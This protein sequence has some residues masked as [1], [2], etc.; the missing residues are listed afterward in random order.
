MVSLI[1]KKSINKENIGIWYNDNKEIKKVVCGAANARDGLLTV[2]APPGAII[3]KNKTKLV[4]AKIRDV[5]S[6][7]M[8]CSESELNLSDESDGITE[9]SSS[10]YAKKIGKSYFS[11]QSSNLIDLSTP[12]NIFKSPNDLIF[13]S[14]VVK[15]VISLVEES[16][17][18]SNCLAL[19]IPLELIFPEAVI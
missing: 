7:G 16:D 6:Y 5:T 4:V 8:L 14:L 15:K 3:P 1:V 12:V 2:Y 10:K 11:K 9:L 19:I 18:S 17:L 13:A